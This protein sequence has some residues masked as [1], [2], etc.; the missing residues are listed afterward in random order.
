MPRERM[1]FAFYEEK[2]EDTAV[3]PEAG[4]GSLRALTYLA[5]GLAGEGGEV[6][7]KIKK[8]DRDDDGIIT[9]TA[10]AAI[11]KE[12]GDGLWYVASMCRELGVTMEEVATLNVLNLAGRKNR[13]T[14]HGN[15][16]DR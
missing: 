10:V 4:S 5:L 7:N 3:Y 8:I 1:S 14:L 2:A 16:D 11:M 13:G 15:G 9:T 6:A 12:L